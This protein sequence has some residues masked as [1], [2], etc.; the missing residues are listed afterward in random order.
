MLNCRSY[1]SAL[2]VISALFDGVAVSGE[3]ARCLY[4]SSY[5]PE[6]EWDAGIRKG[7]MS[8]LAGL[9]DLRIFFMDTKRNQSEEFAQTKAAEVLVQIE[10]F[11]PDVVI[12]ADDNASRYLV[13]PHRTRPGSCHSSSG[14]GPDIVKHCR[15]PR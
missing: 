6:Y 15:R 2:L 9:C 14:V 8:E 3:T 5:H 12:A 1:A 11:K 10:D 4:V 7:L 13:Q